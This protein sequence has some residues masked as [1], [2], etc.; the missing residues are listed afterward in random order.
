M[1]TLIKTIVRKLLIVLPDKLCQV[2]TPIFS[3]I[4]DSGEIESKLLSRFTDRLSKNPEGIIRKIVSRRQ[5]ME[6]KNM[7]W[8]GSYFNVAVLNNLLGLVIYALYKGF[9]PL[10]HINE[11]N[12]NLFSWSWYFKQPLEDYTQGVALES[13]RVLDRNSVEFSPQW[14]YSQ[15]GEEFS[16][17]RFVY[18]TF[19]KLNKETKEYIDSESN[20][21][22]NLDNVLGILMRGTDYISIK[23]QGHPVQ[24]EM[25]EVL[26]KV[27]EVLERNPQ[28]KAVYVAT[29]DERYINIIR[30]ELGDEKI[31]SNNRVYYDKNYVQGEVIGTV[32]FDRENDN[33]LKGLEYLSSMVLLSKC[34]SL[35]AGN[36]GGTKF[37]LLYAP[38]NYRECHVFNKGLYE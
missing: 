31:L 38:T 22:G 1:K 18:Q 3:R 26:Q 8:G 16:R 11:E 23:P 15:K 33:Y 25:E 37:A 24:P 34:D 30:S 20:E 4:I 6:I 9:I 13:I 7:I 28:Y 17:W 5:A 29:D 36:C 2:L 32:H 35:I 14:F 12:D 10:I 27:H 19:V 21:V